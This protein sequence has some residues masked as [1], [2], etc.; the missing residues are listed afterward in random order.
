MH[1]PN[2]EEWMMFLYAEVPAPR[3]AE[4]E[5]HLEVCAHCRER[6]ASWRGTM[7]ALDEWESPV[8][9][10][11]RLRSSFGL[12]LKVAAAVALIGL[13]FA[14]ARLAPRSAGETAAIRAAIEPE[15]RRQVR[16][17]LAALADNSAE[18]RRLLADYIA[19]SESGRARDREEVVD[20]MRQIEARR[21]SDL[22]GL[23]RELETVAVLTENGLEDTQ[24]KLVQ[25]ASFNRD[26]QK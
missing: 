24:S 5:T 9:R 4:L 8:A 1:H 16:A 14:F 21:V 18:T 22:A 15:I 3:K 25:L 20:I 7:A 13:G 26:P 17:E 6:V 11:P 12:S 2:R 19:S 23:R 10:V